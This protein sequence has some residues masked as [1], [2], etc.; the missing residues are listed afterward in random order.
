MECS[1]RVHAKEKEEDSHRHQQEALQP[2][3]LLPLPDEPHEPKYPLPLALSPSSSFT[4]ASRW[5]QSMMLLREALA[6]LGIFLRAHSRKRGS[7][8]S[9]LDRAEMEH[10]R[11]AVAEM[12]GAYPPTALRITELILRAWPTG[13]STREMGFLQLLNVVLTVSPLLPRLEER[14]RVHHRAFARLA[15]CLESPHAGVAEEALL[16]CSNPRVIALYVGVGAPG[17]GGAGLDYINGMV[18]V[19]LGRTIDSHWNPEVR[20]ESRRMRELLNVT[21]CN[22]TKDGERE[23]EIEGGT[24]WLGVDVEGG[25]VV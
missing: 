5:S 14:T 1:D 2:A 16:A 22:G 9:A 23:E 25:L 7:S 21:C 10:M 18:Q 24:G 4:L 6:A 17:G 8:S 11:D 3:P 15:R 19:A 12:I 20:Q 13:Q